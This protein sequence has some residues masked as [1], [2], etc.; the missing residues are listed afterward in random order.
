MSDQQGI[1]HD[2]I[3][4]IQRFVEREV[5]G[6]IEQLEDSDAYPQPLIDQLAEMGL[7]GM[8][9][10]ESYGG[11]E[12]NVATYARI[13]EELA[14]G[15]TT[16]P[17]YLNSHFTASSILNKHGSAAQKEKYL[18][19]MASG[20]LRVAIA[21]TEASGGSD[22]KAMRTVA[23]LQPDGSFRLSGSKMFITN[24]ARAGA[25]LVL[26]KT[27][28]G[29]SEFSLF[30]VEKGLPGFEVGASARTMGHRH[31]DVAELFFND[32][33]LPAESLIGQ[34][35]SHGLGLM[36]EALETGRIAMGATAAGLARSAL[37]AATQY[38]QTR[39]A[40]GKTIADLP[41]IQNMLAEMGTKTLAARLMVE[42][43]ARVKDSGARADMVAGMAKLFASE[44]CGEVALAC[45]R[46]HGGSG[47][48]DDFPAARYYREAPYYMLVEG[49][50]EIQKMIIARR[51]LKGDAAL[52]EL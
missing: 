25:V 29:A 31:V 37:R 52:L 10:P 42:E 22:L 46:I 49:S 11:I 20:A 3:D 47:F 19:A 6:Q 33:P 48:V 45:V 30:L 18:P 4:A 44:A 7:F 27:I 43:A 35:D 13:M 15:W 21:L 32:V 14:N 40:F 36:L 16:L 17:C 8:A 12:L 9:I 50:N 5:I 41:T 28:G 23:K 24:G 39:E 1:N 51:L 38:A 26:C 34:L 2:L